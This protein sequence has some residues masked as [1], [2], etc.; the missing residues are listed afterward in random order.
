[1]KIAIASTGKSTDS[2]LDA[3]FGRCA[4]FA[5]YDTESEQVSFIENSAKLASG[6]AGPAAV[7]LLLKENVSKIVATTFG[8]KIKSMLVDLGITMIVQD[9]EKTIQEIIALTK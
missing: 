3:R 7:T 4:Y 1:M 2:K 6:G 5:I 9:E 8:M